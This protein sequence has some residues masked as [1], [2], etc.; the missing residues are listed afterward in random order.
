MRVSCKYIL[1]VLLMI[2]SAC[3]DTDQTKDDVSPTGEMSSYT[4]SA[5]CNTYDLDVDASEDWQIEV[6]DGWL[7]IPDNQLQGHGKK[8]LHIYVEQ[9]PNEERRQAT[10]TLSSGGQVKK[11]WKIDQMG[12]NEGGE[13]SILTVN[14]K[15]TYGV[16]WGYNAFG[17][18][19]NEKEIRGQVVNY[20]KL[21]A[22]QETLGTDLS[23]TEEQYELNYNKAVA[24]SMSEFSRTITKQSNSKTKVL[25]YK[26]EVNKRTTNTTTIKSECSFATLS[27]LNIVAQR[28]ISEA[29]IKT[30]LDK[31]IDILTEDFRLSILKVKDGDMTPQNFIQKYGTDVV[32]TAWLGGR[33]DYTTT[34]KKT[35]TT[36]IEQVVT[37]TYKKLF[38]KSSSM[39][40]EEKRFS[41]KIQTDY[42]CT[43][44]VKG[45]NTDGL[46]KE[47]ESK[48]KNK[49]P[50][51]DNVFLA[52]EQSF[53][54]ASAML[55]SDKAALVDTRTIP[56]YE[57]ITDKEVRQRI[58]D[59]INTEAGKDVFSSDATTTPCYVIDIPMNVDELTLA[60]KNDKTGKVIAE[61][62]KEFVPS[63]RAD[64]RV[65]VVYPVLSNGKPNLRQGFFIGDG[66]ANA[67]GRVLWKDGISYY[68][69]NENYST[70]DV[71]SKLYSYCD[72]LTSTQENY[73][74]PSEMTG[75]ILA[76]EKITIAPNSYSSN[77]NIRLVKVGEQ[78][79]GYI[80]S[81]SYPCRSNLPFAVAGFRLPIRT[82]MDI[83]QKT[84]LNDFSLLFATDGRAGLNFEQ[85]NFPLMCDSKPLTIFKN[86]TYVYYDSRDIDL[87]VN[88]LL[89]RNND[90]SYD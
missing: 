80:S 4:W 43:C 53:Q 71:V 88:T 61:I 83:L 77:K 68:Y 65:V 38:K 5:A 39:S 47:I 30:L 69:R 29:Q 35:T 72:N 1:F 86:G 12:Y 54:D 18:Y 90:F 75:T 37:T 57:L 34:I 22:N 6:S 76:T 16:G 78:Y 51:D 66:E 55:E 45:G 14:L 81:Y 82:D 41:E 36:E 25:F 87:T 3:S 50:I 73:M 59:E 9:N 24:H 21:L 44:D 8:T 23:T 27:V 62:C 17:E 19:A 56:I 32:L 89:V 13:N 46:D 40:E 60:V 28:Y 58:E 2:L 64:K 79:W 63:I 42:D 85:E 31:N 26:K 70:A 33:L 20:G 74:Q 11:T 7:F 84:L 48:I 49:Q 52:W 15:K 10:I 67:P